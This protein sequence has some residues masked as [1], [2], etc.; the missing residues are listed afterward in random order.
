[1]S[2][3]AFGLLAACANASQA[4][5]SKG[6]TTRFPAR[7]LIGVLYVF[8]CLVLLPFA[9][10]TPWQWS[11]EIVALHLFS[12]ALMAVTA[13]CVW[14]MFDKGAASATTTATALSP[15]PAALGAALLVPG[16]VGLGQIVAAAVVV[17]GVLWALQGA[18]GDLG[19]R[20][21]ILRVLGAAIGTGLL[22]VV[23]HVLAEDGVGLVETYVVRT[24]LA[25]ALF[26][27][28]IPPR[29]VPLA[30]APQLF[31]RSIVVT[32]SF[33]FIILGVQDGSPVVVQTLVAITPLLA[34]AWESARAG[35]RP[36][37][38]AVAGA[39]VV[40]LGVALVLA[41]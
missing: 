10:F 36:P 12:V 30:S 16:S 23:T 40:L 20:G 38:R 11:S 6:L 33:V 1:M 3:I 25:A 28:V 26:V 4:V 24:G 5:I 18:F 41:A 2:A 37:S 14:D 13:I 8:N 9:P 35:Q 31:V 32:L 17:V 29:D 21:T 22:T 7:Q 39:L 15:I 19:R 27:A 34:L